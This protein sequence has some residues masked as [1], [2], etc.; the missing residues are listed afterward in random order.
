ME[1]VKPGSVAYALIIALK[2]SLNVG[3]SI[4]HL[5]NNR[6]ALST[7]SKVQDSVAQRRPPFSTTTAVVNTFEA[8]LY[9]KS[10]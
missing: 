4:K 2:G 9:H 3:A 7:L 6:L 10:I 5:L 1:H 8:K